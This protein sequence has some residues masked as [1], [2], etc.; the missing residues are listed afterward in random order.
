MKTLSILFH[1]IFKTL[2]LPL[3]LLAFLLASIG[4]FLKEMVSI[5]K[6]WYE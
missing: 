2:L 1:I 3:F 6:E 5:I 4:E